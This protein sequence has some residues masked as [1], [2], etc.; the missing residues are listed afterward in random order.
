MPSFLKLHRLIAS[1]L[2]VSVVTNASLANHR[3][4]MAIDPTDKVAPIESQPSM[5]V[6]ALTPASATTSPTP[7]K[8]HASD[9]APEDFF[10]FSVAIFG[11]TALVGANRADGE[12]GD[13]DTGA[14]YVFTRYG[15]TWRQQAKLTAHDARAGDTL[16]G[17]VAIWA[18][19]AIAG[20]IGDDKKGN[21]A[22][23]VYVF[24][25]RDDAWQQQAKLIAADGDAGDAFGQNV[26]ILGDTI[27]VGTPHDDDK[28][29]GSGSAYVFS[30]YG[31]SWKQEAKLTASYGFAGDL[32]GIS[33]ALTSDTILV[34][35]D[36]N[37]EK[38][39]DAG[40]AYIFVRA[41]GHWVEQ[42]KLTAADG[43]ETDIFGVR[44]ALSGDTALV[45]ARRDDDIDM[46]VDAGSVYVFTRSGT[47][48]HQQAKLLAPDGNV[49]DRFG[50][51][52]AL[53]QNTALIG[54]MHQDDR[55]DNS[56]AAYIFRRTG[57][58]WKFIAKITAGDVAP[59]DLLGWSVAMSQ[60]SALIAAARSD[61]HGKESGAAYIFDFDNKGLVFVPK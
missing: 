49:D 45:S 57:T 35:A 28:G 8:I 19:T 37:D 58:S 55:G 20:A 36:L 44:V 43:A 53:Y 40:A 25:R 6:P 31:D 60:N 29:D 41:G 11:N 27:V 26:A 33:V 38:A 46:G 21:N 4:T 24:K 30:R 17:S 5:M 59:G 52:V 51:D 14:A 1:L 39:T 9:G 2:F 50:R 56:G 13:V 32:F 61:A 10:G 12:N 16:G 3:E 54:A 18:D 22:G 23:A 48:W 34:G 42:A 7:N 15:N 47:T